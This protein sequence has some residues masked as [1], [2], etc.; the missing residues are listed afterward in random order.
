MNGIPE[1]RLLDAFQ[2]GLVSHAVYF[3]LVSNYANPIE[4]THV[5]WSFRVSPRCQMV[6]IV[7]VQALYA[8]RLWKLAQIG[9]PG[10]KS[11]I[12]PWIVTLLVIAATGICIA[13]SKLIY[14]IKDFTQFDLIKWA[15]FLGLITASVVDILIAASLCF[16]LRRLRT[17]MAKTNSVLNSLMLYFLNTGVLTSLCSLSAVSLYAAYPHN[18][19]FLA[20]EFPMTKL[21]VNAFIAMFNARHRLQAAIERTTNAS[22]LPNLGVFNSG[23]LTFNKPG[24]PFSG[25]NSKIA[26]TS[27]LAGTVVFSHS[28]VENDNSHSLPTEE[29]MSEDSRSQIRQRGY[30]DSCV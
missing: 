21:Y 11:K 18:F 17:G 19:I 26:P 25:E 4:L 8:R 2:L 10:F 1:F 15:T 16:T 20:V 13:V 5:V 27:G 24:R 30:G 12:V 6:T 3:Y 28:I 7:T 14:T 22:N 9:G 29:S 23:P